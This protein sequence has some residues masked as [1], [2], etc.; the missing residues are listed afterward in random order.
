MENDVE[1]GRNLGDTSVRHPSEDLG[2]YGVPFC[3]HSVGPSNQEIELPAFCSAYH[4]DASI[5]ALG[6]R[7]G[8]PSADATHDALH[9][10][11]FLEE[12]RERLRD[13]LQRPPSGTAI[14]AFSE[15]SNAVEG[16]T[17][18][19]VVVIA[20]TYTPRSGSTTQLRSSLNRS[21]E[22]DAFWTSSFA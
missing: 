13:T 20:D 6:V 8:R 10:V 2:R 22:K 21:A 14:N 7:Q 15:P 16:V 18:T 3:L 9:C 19:D 12:N 4:C 17:D 11:R 1:V 5:F